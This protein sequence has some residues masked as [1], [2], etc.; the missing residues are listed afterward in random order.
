MGISNITQAPIR[1]P[2][3]Q[4]TAMMPGEWLAI[5]IFFFGSI[6]LFLIVLWAI[7][8]IWGNP[9]N[10]AKNSRLSGD[11]IIIHFETGK[12]AFLKLSQVMAHAFRHRKVSDGTLLAIPKGVNYLGAHQVVISWGLLGMSVPIFLLGAITR[13][14]S[15]NYATREQLNAAVTATP[16]FKQINLIDDGYNFNDFKDVIHKS[17]NPILLPLEIEHTSDF[18][19]SINQHYTESEVNKELDSYLMNNPD[20]FAK[21]ILLTT[22]C[23]AIIGVILW[24]LIGNGG[25]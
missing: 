17:Q 23:V 14:K 13:L 18:V 9:I 3:E 1:P 7:T 15:L 5:I 8:I 6:I 20:D 19:Q 12:N 11:A 24:L 22:V 16:K 10:T 2:V 21:V 4:A 25:K